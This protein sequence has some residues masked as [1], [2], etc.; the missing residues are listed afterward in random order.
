MS[1]VWPKPEFLNICWSL[2]SRLFK[3]SCLFTGQ[4]VQQGSNREDF[5]FVDRKDSFVTFIKD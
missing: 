2:K 1:F 5:L 4:K 3:K